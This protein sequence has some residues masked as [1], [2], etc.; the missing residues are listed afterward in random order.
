MLDFT[1]LQ[2]PADLSAVN[3]VAGEAVKFPADY[4]LRFASLNAR[5]HIGKDWTARNLGRP[6]FNKGFND[7]QIFA[8]GKSSQLGKL[9]VN[10]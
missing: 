10:G 2:H 6:L 9:R 1:A 3:W 4:A 8:L 5:K 7:M